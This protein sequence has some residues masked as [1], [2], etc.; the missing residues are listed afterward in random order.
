MPYSIL[1]TADHAL[2]VTCLGI[3]SVLGTSNFWLASRYLRHRPA[4]LGREARLLS[5]TLPAD[6]DLPDI[7]LQLPT[8]N[9]R[10]LILRAAEAAEKLDWPRNRLHVQIL[11]DSTDAQ[12]RNAAQSAVALLRRAGINAAVMTREN[13]SG[14]KAGALAGGLT[15]SSAEF[16]AI[17]DAD[18][19]PAPDFLRLCM[20][21]LLSD[22]RVG[23]VQGRCD[24]INAAENRITWA[25]QRI[26]D[27]HFAI[28]QAARNW[29]GHLMPF[30]GTCG[31]WRRAAIE[32]AGGWS[33]DTLAEDLDLSY[34]AQLKGWAALFLSTVAVKG[35]LPAS[36][37]VWRQQQFRWTKG[38]AEGARKLLPRVW[39]SHLSLSQ[40]IVSSWH[41][42]SGML[43]P[44]AAL[45]VAAGAVDL[46]LGYGPTWAS[47]LL[48]LWSLV[49]GALIGPALLM[50]IAQIFVRGSRLSFELP[51]L[52]R[53]LFLQI[54]T[55]LGNIGGAIEALVGRA[56]A[57]ER[58]P[59][60]G[61]ALPAATGV[62]ASRTRS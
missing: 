38:F 35:E 1:L 55:A 9:E 16:V 50:V 5:R 53:V 24:Y 40:K 57:F 46:L 52:P 59:K 3:H 34:R 48:L 15:S 54:A 18:Y 23:F 19:T 22:P 49:G 32:S 14:F 27:A 26:L 43:G 13:R 45:T 7:L 4:A 58:T 2:F 28:E 61:A 29:S 31:I 21:A 8:F 11:D 47:T 20:K 51:R 37:S 44:L 39:R 25:Q 62:Y 36:L 30:N 6:V 17:L 41:L 56:S 33:S 10:G 12:S 42:A 60:G